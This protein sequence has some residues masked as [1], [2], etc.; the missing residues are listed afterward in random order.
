MHRPN[1][2]LVYQLEGIEVDLT[3]GCLT[4]KGQEHYLRQQAFDVLR[5][6]LEN[7]QRL[8]TKED[9][10]EGIWHGVSVTDNALVQCVTEIRKAIGDDSHNPR[11]IR[12]VPKIGYRFIGHVEERGVEVLSAQGGGTAA[13]V[14]DNQSLEP[15]PL[16]SMGADLLRKGIQRSYGK[17]AAFLGFVG[18]GA[19]VYLWLMYRPFDLPRAETVLP[20][21]PGKKA[22]AVMYFEN[23]SARPEFD[24]LREGLADMFITD[25]ARNNNLTVLSRQQLHLLM[26][27]IGHK[28]TEKVRLDEALEI[29][30]RS[31]AAEVILGH[32]AALGDEVRLDVQVHDAQ[33]GRLMA[34]DSVVV[35][36]PEE[37]L[38]QVDLLAIRLASRLGDAS[39]DSPPPAS[40]LPAMTNNLEAYRYYSLG[41]EKA[42]AFENSQAIRLLRKAID[43]DPQFAMAYARIGY[44]Y[45][46]TDF[47]PEKGTPYLEKAFQLSDRLTE[48]DKLYLTSWYAIARGDY[49]SAIQTSRRI[50]AL[51]PSEIEAYWRLGRLLHGE[52]QPEEA[53]RV[54]QLGLTVDPGAKELYNGLGINYLV[55]GRYD[56][57]IRALQR[58]V[59]LA[60]REPNAYDSLGMSYQQSG[61]Y[62]QAIAVYSK[63]VALDSEF[64]P[65]IIHLG[66]TYFQQGRYRDAI[67]QYERYIAVTRSDV[68][69]GLGYSNIA[70]VYLSEGN[71]SR[72]AWAARNEMKYAPGSVW[73]ALRIAMAR[74]DVRHVRVLEQKLFGQWPYSERGARTDLRSLD[75]I[76]GYLKLK[77]DG[78]GEEA[79]EFF[80]EALH[81]LPPTSGIELHEDCLANAYLELGRLDEAIGE[82]R[83]ILRVNANYPL[84]AFHLA[85]AY[86]RKGERDQARSFY[87]LFL[88]NWKQADANVQQIREANEALSRLRL[89]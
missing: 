54:L 32:F 47:V 82:Y 15:V 4:V 48:K 26:E 28:S 18:T 81:H 56:D 39:S 1:A 74:N 73:N 86:E 68:A 65:A 25:L 33:N 80:K 36:R 37:I 78:A 9:L 62:E 3:R 89:N 83:R 30:S 19:L 29:A 69:R 24:W 5:F 59:E 40:L 70:H 76:R 53:V 42:Q 2:K 41:V 46:V 61:R 10:M 14:S 20:N 60:P 49:P 77:G 7:R 27:R 87:E 85:Q 63:A 8:V 23:E 35:G 38:S 17:L 84:A 75:Y 22:I 67:T 72:A 58:Y 34:A 44:A 16:D 6:L 55:V 52:E 64:E 51:Y 50:I 88:Q 45:A 43:L 21:L 71:L 57:A 12:T 31:R 13:S 79:V 66:D 11:F